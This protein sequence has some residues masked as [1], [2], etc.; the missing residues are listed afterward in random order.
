MKEYQPPPPP[1]PSPPP[2]AQPK[3][4]TEE[5]QTAIW[6]KTRAKRVAKQAAKNIKSCRQCGLE[7]HWRHMESRRVHEETEPEKVLKRRGTA[8]EAGDVRAME[9]E[10]EAGATRPQY[11]WDHLC[12]EC[13][14]WRDNLSIPMAARHV[15]GKKAASAVKRAADFKQAM[16]NPQESIAVVMG[17]NARAGEHA[18]RAHPGAVDDT[19]VI[20]DDLSWEE[21]QNR[22]A[23]RLAELRTLS[24]EQYRE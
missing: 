14:A 19:K 6:R 22:A 12:V 9:A 4:D 2:P 5:E 17:Y 20:P 1:P 11:Q 18:R 10:A 7:D 16:D 24:K 21:V 8:A 23:E 15:A 3:M 13:V